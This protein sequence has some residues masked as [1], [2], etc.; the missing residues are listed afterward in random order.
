MITKAKA[1]KSA[2]KK[3]TPLL[4]A[5]EQH[6]NALKRYVMRIIHAENDVED[7]VQEAFMRA[8]KS[9]IEGDIRQPKSYLFR[10]AKHVALN[11][12]RQKVNRPTDFLEDCD[13]ASV[14]V[15]S[16]TMEDEV[17][18]QE[19]LG[20]HCMAVAALPPRRRKVYLMRKVYG[21]SQKSIAES[22]GI[23]VSTVEAHLAKAFKECHLHVKARFGDSQPESVRQSKEGRL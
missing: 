21:M 16:W 2:D 17:L 13:P 5:Y 1:D 20:I 9:E 11:Q 18:A 23:T 4:A 3:S 22:L 7:V 6:L 12:I 15:E 14:L 8:Y 19:R 10:V